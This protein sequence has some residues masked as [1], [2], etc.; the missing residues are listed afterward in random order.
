M[1]KRPSPDSRRAN[2]GEI[3]AE[4]DPSGILKL[5]LAGHLDS[6]STGGVWNQAMAALDQASAK[7]IVVDATDVDYCD[8]SGIGLFVE[9]RRRQLKKG[10][11]FEIHGLRPKFR[12]LLDLFDPSAFPGVP[13][14]KQKS[15]DIP[16]EIGLAA[17][18]L[19]KETGV[20]VAFVGEVAVALG[21]VAMHP[22][23][24]RWGQ[25]AIVA[26]KAGVN[27]LPIVAL[28]SFLVG[29]IMAF[30]AAIPMRQFGAEIYVADLIALSMLRELGPLMTAIVLTG[31]SGSAFAAEL[32][33]MKVNEEIDAL[34]TMGLDPVRFLVV[35]RI[36]AAVAVT[37][38]L[39]V[40]ADLVGVLGGSIVL[41]SLGYPLLTYV[42]EVISATTHVDLLGGL[43]KSAVFGIVV[44]GV[45]CLRGMETGIG[46]TAVG[47]STTRAVVAGIVLIVV[48]DGVFSVVFYQLGI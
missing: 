43:M 32:G 36:I 8:I 5:H 17:C 47:D 40:F 31:R 16:L 2:P 37:P 14:K 25:V 10:G 7:R 45:G 11:E 27:A 21:R 19:W 1:A 9:V 12:K 15:I 23:G 4:F 35:P 6:G 29:L 33:T 48:I 26:E 28:V 24:I 41:V 3:R 34:T 39:A 13:E 46:A 22:R 30:Q 42:K 20:F 18:R 38:L 44:A